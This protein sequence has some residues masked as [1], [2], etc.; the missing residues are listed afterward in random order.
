MNIDEYK[1]KYEQHVANL[2]KVRSEMRKAADCYKRKE[3]A[4]ETYYMCRAKAMADALGIS[5]DEFFYHKG[6]IEIEEEV[7]TTLID[8][9]DTYYIDYLDRDRK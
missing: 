1:R 5:S 9:D 4:K 6:V 7:G 2:I 8:G 3:Y